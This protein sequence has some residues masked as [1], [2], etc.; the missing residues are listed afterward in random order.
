VSIS[1]HSQTNVLL[2]ASASFSPMNHI[3]L[4][5]RSWDIFPS[6]I[7]GVIIQSP[8]SSLSRHVNRLLSKT[9]PSEFDYPGHP[10]WPPSNRNSTLPLDHLTVWTKPYR[11]SPC[12]CSTSSHRDFIPFPID[13]LIDKGKKIVAKTHAHASRLMQ[14]TGEQYIRTE[15]DDELGVFITLRECLL[16]I[17]VVCVWAEGDN[18]Y[19]LSEMEVSIGRTFS[20]GRRGNVWD[21]QYQMANH[22]WRQA[23]LRVHSVIIPL[24]WEKVFCIC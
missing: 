9:H 14:T 11:S 17:P 2:P 12:S 8:S 16:F 23:I 19:R 3:A 15:I 24:W 10:L 4:E 22:C 18:M 7:L 20:M 1:S 5:T 21:F 13:E 6:D